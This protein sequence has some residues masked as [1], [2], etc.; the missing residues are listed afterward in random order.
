MKFDGLSYTLNRNYLFRDAHIDENGKV[1]EVDPRGDV[2]HKDDPVIVRLKDCQHVETRL[3]VV[4]W[5][6]GT[7]TVRPDYKIYNVHQC[8]KYVP[9]FATG[10]TSGYFAPRR[11]GKN[12]RQ[13][14]ISE[15]VTEMGTYRTVLTREYYTL[16]SFV[17]NNGKVYTRT[18]YV[19]PRQAR[20]IMGEALREEG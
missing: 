10:T 3:R 9:S 11:A 13:R 8:E 12:A 20:H 19:S 7:V 18:D 14:T 6:D 1:I 16:T 17:I 4:E 15:F 5:G 2:I